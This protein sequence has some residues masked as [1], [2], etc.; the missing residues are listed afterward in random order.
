MAAGRNDG[1]RACVAATDE[2]VRLKPDATD[3]QLQTRSAFRRT[4]YG[5]T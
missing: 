2:A 3:T 1:I 4:N 5:A